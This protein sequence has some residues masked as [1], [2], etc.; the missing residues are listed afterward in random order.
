MLNEETKSAV[1]Y[2]GKDKINGAFYLDGTNVVI[3]NKGKGSVI[4]HHSAC[5]ANISNLKYEAKGEET[6]PILNVDITS[7]NNVSSANKINISG[8][9]FTSETT[10]IVLSGLPCDLI[11]DNATKITSKSF[12]IENTNES[13]IELNNSIINSFKKIH[14]D[15]A[16]NGKLSMFVTLNSNSNYVFSYDRAFT[17][18][19]QTALTPYIEAVMANGT[20]QEIIPTSVVESTSGVMKTTV[21]FKTP[22]GI[23]TAKNIRIGVQAKDVAVSASFDNWQL[24]LADKFEMATGENLIDSNKVYN[25]QELTAYDVGVDENVIMVE[26]SFDETT[27]ILSSITGESYNFKEPHIMM[28][29]GRNNAVTQE[30]AAPTEDDPDKTIKVF[31]EVQTATNAYLYQEIMVEAGKTYKVS[32]NV[33]YAATGSGGLVPNEKF[34]IELSYKKSGNYVAAPAVKLPEDSTEYIETYLLTIPDDISPDTKNFKFSFYFGSMYVSGYLA[35]ISVVEVDAVTNAVIGEELI[36]NGDFSTGD[37]SYWIISGSYARATVTK[38][39]ENYFSKVKS[40]AKGMRYFENSDNYAGKYLVV[41]Y[42]PNTKYEILYQLKTITYNPDHVP[43]LVIYRALYTDDKTD[44]SLTYL[45][46]E[47]EANP[48]VSYEQLDNNRY[49]VVIKTDDNLR[50]HNFHTGD[51]RFQSHT[52]SAGYYGP[53]EIYE[54]DENGNRVSGN[55]ALNGDFALGMD[56]WEN[57]DPF[58]LSSVTYE[59]ETG[60]LDDTTGPT[61]MVYIDGSTKNQNY[62]TTITV[63]ASKNYWFSG[64]YINM[65]SVGIT[66]RILYQSRKANG[67]YEVLETELKYNSV[68]YRFEMSVEIPEDAVVKNGKAILKVQMNNGNN[69]RAYFRELRFAEEGKFTNLIESMTG[70]SSFQEIPYDPS[71][72]VFYYDDSS[73]DDGDWS[74]E[75]AEYAATTGA[76]SG[77]VVN[78]KQESVAGIT[79]MLTPG[80]N[81]VKTDENGNYSFTNLN[82]GNYELYL[83]E[84]NGNKLLCYDVEVKAGILSNIPLITYLDASELIVEIPEDSDGDTTVEQTPYGA[85]RGYYLDKDGNPIKGAKIYLKGLGFVETNAK[86]MFEFS[87]LPVGE[88]EVYTKLDDGT[89]HVFRKVEIEAYKGS[90]IKL[91]EPT[92]GGFNWLWVIIPSASVV[93][94]AGAAFVTILIIKKKKTK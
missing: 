70:P 13:N 83:V 34:G 8:C 9:E 40:Y 17:K 11:L 43:G 69:G 55:I 12:A 71:V 19:D 18:G 27:V 56:G 60:F 32:A 44:S 68:A 21:T 65:N 74:G 4:E 64:F 2:T 58:E 22:E 28:F 1:I 80:N 7:G 39:V 94:L 52:D 6:A 20:T 51:V 42:K 49:R 59:Q 66:P 72:F 81:T 79:M 88:Y 23:A 53:V 41:N 26:G 3:N 37:R 92:T 93:L 50:R 45:D 24:F 75:L 91:V 89:V 77:R 36:K 29:M 78:S 25:T 57:L 33:K 15:N 46:H 86:G 87:K 38:Y 47:D 14:L 63:D 16:V 54:L 10:P 85:L 67:A 35:N 5:I 90:L 61:S 84:A 73:F 62:S 31:E 82:P 48:D 30:V 76:V